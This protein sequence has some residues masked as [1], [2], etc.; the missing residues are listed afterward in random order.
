MNLGGC[1]IFHDK[2]S[3]CDADNMHHLTPRDLAELHLRYGIGRKYSTQEDLCAVP[4]GTLT[5]GTLQVIAKCLQDASSDGDESHKNRC[6][7]KRSAWLFASFLKYGPAPRQ[8]L[9]RLRAFTERAGTHNFYN[10]YA[11]H[12]KSGTGKEKEMLRRQWKAWRRNRTRSAGAESDG[13][14]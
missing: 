3:Y 8:L 4:E 6:K 13:A 1:I 12:L 11:Y 7:R 14:A 10:F 5:L 2:I 9:V